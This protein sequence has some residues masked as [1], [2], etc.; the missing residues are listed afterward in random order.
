[1]FRDH[2]QRSD[3]TGGRARRQRCHS[4]RRRSSAD[5]GAT[6][7]RVAPSPVPSPHALT[8]HEPTACSGVRAPGCQPCAHEPLVTRPC[9]WWPPAQGRDLCRA[10]SGFQIGTSTVYRYVR[11]AIKLLAAM[12]PTLAQS[13]EVARGKAPL[14]GRTGQPLQPHGSHL[15]Q[16]SRAQQRHL[17]MH[18]LSTLGK[19]VST[20]LRTRPMKPLQSGHIPATSLFGAKLA[21]L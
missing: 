16:R 5:G 6:R 1:M 2:N 4:R 12:A 7:S 14:H 11:E 10:A 20:G 19:K 8:G 15:P 17:V 13:I 21:S 9:W 3:R 18:N